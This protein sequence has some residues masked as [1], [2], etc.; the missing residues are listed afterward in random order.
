MFQILQSD[1]RHETHKCHAS[2]GA[3]S[4][5][6][7]TMTI[8]SF[9]AGLLQ[10]RPERLIEKVEVQE[11]FFK[12]RQVDLLTKSSLRLLLDRTVVY[13]Q[14]DSEITSEIWSRRE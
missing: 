1:Q 7:L 14:R 12:Q 11:G 10:V 5:L 4:E 6:S 2:T 9:V 3:W 8:P 13:I